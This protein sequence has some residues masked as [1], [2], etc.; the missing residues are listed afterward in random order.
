MM[1]SIFI[2]FIIL[3]LGIETIIYGQS[4]WRPGE[5]EIRVSIAGPEEA[6]KLAGFELNGD[7]YTKQGFALL[8]VTPGELEKLKS[9]GIH[10]EIIKKDLNAFYKDF[11]SNRDQYHSY[12]EI[13]QAIDS[14]STNYPAICK[15][16]DYGLSLEGRQLCALKISD[17]VNTDEP[18][19][20]IMF[21]GGIHGDEIGGPENL[22]RFAEFLCDSY[23]SDP[24]I[25]SLIN[26][27]EIWLYIMVNPDG[28][29]NMVRYNSNG[30]DLNRDWG[31]MWNAAGSSP[32][33]YSQPETRALRACMLS[34]Q[35]AIH[36]T[37]HSGTVFLAFPWSYRPDSC[38]DKP[39]IQQ[40]AGIYASSSGYAELP[41]EQGYTGMYAINGSSKDA[42]Y[43]VMG[44][45]SWTMEIS[46]N[47][48]PPAS[49]IQYYYDINKPAMIEMIRQAGYGISGTVTDA[50]LG[51]PVAATIFVDDFFPCYADPMIG[52]YHKYLLA[53]TYTVTAVANGYHPLTQTLTVAE[54]ANTALDFSLSQEVNHFA[55]RVIACRIPGN[56]FGDEGRTD[57]ALWEPDGICYS[58]GRS[59]WII[60]DMKDDILNGPGN[61]II[62]HEGGS[63][64][65]G[66]ALYASESMDGLWFL[67]GNATGTSSFDLGACG[68]NTARYLRI[69]DD[70]DGPAYGDNVGFDLDA[71]EI[72]EQ[73]EVI[74]LVV[75]CL[76]ED[77]SGN[78]NNRIDPGE[79]FNLVVTISNYGTLE[80]EAGQAY[81]NVDQQFI[82][83]NNPEMEIG[84]LD[85]GESAQLVFSMT[86][87]FICPPANC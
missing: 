47:K 6:A 34:N 32:G 8:Y 79:N 58:L 4:S 5:I 18:E 29:V 84:D 10:Y 71:V 63:D 12:E 11:W 16:F 14:L 28:R 56:N 53:G 15:K 57:A 78:Q 61:E 33:Y 74:Y 31:Y 64:P 72:P 45:V 55:Y 77:P 85:F 68:L 13:I 43:A 54:N 70:G 23:G 38:P 73:P 19:P 75:D 67:I 69:E 22:V 30:V 51:I 66:Y 3:F 49:Q 24:E 37:Y 81:L 86:C 46:T 36:I 65:E 48:Q 50:N 44:S 21:D 20:E 80:M 60:L 1:K 40:L 25:T 35:F 83:V 59:G 27:R 26:D 39:H 52:D 82:S 7:I 76:I 41:V 17:N 87:S 9:S 62:I 2:S 42:N